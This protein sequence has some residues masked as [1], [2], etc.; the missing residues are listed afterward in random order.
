MLAI[1]NS[2]A[3]RA[4][5]MIAD[6][7]L[8]ARPPA[9]VPADVD[10]NDVVQTVV[11]ELQEEAALQGTRFCVC[12]AEEPIVVLADPAQLAVALRAICVNALEA[13]VAEGTIEVTV[14]QVAPSGGDPACWARVAVHD[15]G[16]G[17]P[18]DIRSHL[19]D[20][21]YSGREAGRGLGLGLSKCWRIVTLN[22]G[23]VE[24]VSQERQ[25][26]TVTVHLPIPV[27]TA[28]VDNLAVKR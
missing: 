13:L 4:N 8:F 18:P 7:M 6:M 16:P 9:P 20:P 3:F 14:D 23:R 5:E 26:T 19:F 1:I 24:V 25:G 27:R 22:G 28:P 12:V 17:I 21:F 2:Q 11:G 15:G 10:V